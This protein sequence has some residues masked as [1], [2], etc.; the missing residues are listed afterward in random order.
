MFGNGIGSLRVIIYDVNSAEDKVIWMISGEAGNAWYQGQ[1][2]ISSATTFKVP[3]DSIEL[4]SFKVQYSPQSLRA[5]VVAA[6]SAIT[7]EFIYL[8]NSHHY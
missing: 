2:P 5:T 1:V 4:F 3:P 7:P 8:I 6:A